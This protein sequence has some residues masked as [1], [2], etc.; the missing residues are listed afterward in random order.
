MSRLQSS[1]QLVL[2]GEV[3][4]AIELLGL[5]D[6]RVQHIVLQTPRTDLLI[7]VLHFGTE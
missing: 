2:S 7:I 4:V 5:V 1:L 6:T 3:N